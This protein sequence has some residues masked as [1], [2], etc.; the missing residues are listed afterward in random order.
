MFSAF[1]MELFKPGMNEGNRGLERSIEVTPENGFGI[2][3]AI[4]GDI[5]HKRAI[6]P[7]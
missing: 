1:Y 4:W 5:I 3:N 6:P 7:R 2:N